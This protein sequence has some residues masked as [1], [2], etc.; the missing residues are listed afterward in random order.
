[1][2][3]FGILGTTLTDRSLD[4]ML[5]SEAFRCVKSQDEQE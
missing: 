5:E 4:A 1:M 2:Q 3:Q